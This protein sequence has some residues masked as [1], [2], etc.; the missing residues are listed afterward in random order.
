MSELRKKAFWEDDVLA[1]GNAVPGDDLLHPELSAS[2]PG[3]ALTETQY[4]G[5]NIPEHGI[6]AI[7]YLWYHPNLK[8]VM[9][10]IAVWQGFK[11]HSLQSEIWDY[12]SYMSDECLKNDLWSYQLENGYTVTTVEPMKA[13]RIQYENAKL[14]NFVDV[15][16]EALMP[17][18]MQGTGLHFEQP[19]RTR[20]EIRLRGKTYTVD[21]T[22]VRD[23]SFG[24]LRREYLVALPP[25]A[26]MN[27]AFS[28]H[29]SF[30]CTAFD[31]P[32]R[33][34][35]WH[36]HFSLPNG[37]PLRGGWVYRDSVLGKIV[38]ASKVTRRRPGSFNPDHVELTVFD[39]RGRT[40]EIQGQSC[41]GVPWQGWPNMD[42]TVN[43]MR[44]EC[45][46]AVTYGDYQEF[47]WPEY[48]RLFHP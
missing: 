8:T 43:L 19:V 2:E 9:G 37:N 23:R 45:D 42:A 22:S 44:W 36:G 47:L 41:A 38:K 5:F 24:Q 30:G 11:R 7:G 21:G 26:W 6:H 35:E 18:V 1:F 14:D 31:D 10:G 48:V 34:P 20:G 29:F 3:Y 28:E 25:L 27:A 46:G 40:F 15:H 32:Q 33:K 12:V 39:D 17:P 4:L 13:H 16:F